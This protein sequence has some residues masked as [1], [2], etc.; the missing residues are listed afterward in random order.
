MSLMFPWDPYKNLPD[1]SKH[2]EEWLK[3]T[4]VI[5]KRRFDTTKPLEQDFS[6]DQ[7]PSEFAAMMSKEV[8]R[9]ILDARRMIC[10]SQFR[11]SRMV[12]EIITE[13]AFEEQWTS[14]D[15]KKRLD[16]ILGAFRN[17]ESQGGATSLSTF[18]PEKLN[19]PEVSRDALLKN[20]GRGYLELAKQFLL[21]N[22]DDV[23][24]KPFILVHP[25]FD[26][27][28]GYDPD[29]TETA[30]KSWLD[31]R[32]LMRTYYIGN[33][34]FGI[35]AKYKGHELTLVPTT[36]E[37]YKTK[38]TLDKMRP[39]FD[40]I[41]GPTAG[42]A[43]L[44]E[45]AKLRKEMKLFCD[46][47]LKPED[48]A[49]GGKMSACARCKAVDREVRYCNKDC[50]KAA[51]K[52]HKKQCGKDLELSSILQDVE[53]DTRGQYIA[54]LRPDIPPASTGYKRSPFLLRLIRH[55]NDERSKDYILYQATKNPKDPEI[56]SVSLDETV[57]AS[58]FCVMRNRA[59]CTGEESAI[60]Y[61][62][63]VLQNRDRSG[64][65]H[66]HLRKQMK[67]EYEGAWDNVWAELCAGR[68]PKVRQVNRAEIEEAM[69]QLHK[70]K[71]FPELEF[72]KPG[73]GKAETRGVAVGPEK[74]VIVMV[75]F[76]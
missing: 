70:L 29:D 17:Q 2:T 63:R 76:P 4:D 52:M 57:G 1:A 37:H 62:Y 66:E 67:D 73:Q 30:R 49:Q 41:L 46:H 68:L 25:H 18:G 55:L 59:M 3:A 71:R 9:E 53:P 42:K 11:L 45:Q 35:I 6:R 28:I 61:I 43:Y 72:F 36:H 13:E 47:C 8:L 54:Q 48:K 75:E 65:A 33:V 24:T 51:W 27:L 19:C 23:P 38:E 34:V 22:N 44:K 50:Q 39:V 32:R 21:D 74:D 60:L 15:E 10:S 14:M 40:H 56:Y 7:A 12:A 31:A 64:T 16:I 58:V 26:K 5:S 69:T 20:G